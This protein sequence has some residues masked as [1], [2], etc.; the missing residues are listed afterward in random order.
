MVPDKRVDFRMHES[1]RG[2]DAMASHSQAPVYED[3]QLVKWMETQ[4]KHDQER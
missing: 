3:R 1:G 4:S 2:S